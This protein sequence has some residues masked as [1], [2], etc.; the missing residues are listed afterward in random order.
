MSATATYTEPMLREAVA[1]SVSMA[2]VLRYL[3]LR[4]AGGTQTYLTAKIKRLGIDTS[5]FTR[6]AHNRGKTSPRRKDWQDILVVLPEGS[7]RIRTLQLRRAMLDY[8]FAWECSECGQGPEWNGKPLV[9]EIDHIDG[10]WLDNTPENLRFIC[11]NCH[12]QQE[13]KRSWRFS[14]P[15]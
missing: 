8:G 5:H 6:Q 3:N 12:S 7:S 13:T 15:L 11:A 1:N 9:L 2:G 4:Q 10:N 14:K